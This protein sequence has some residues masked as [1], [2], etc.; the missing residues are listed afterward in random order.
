MSNP[1]FELLN[2]IYDSITKNKLPFG[3]ACSTLLVVGTILFFNPFQILESDNWKDWKSHE[4]YLFGAFLISII[5]VICFLFIFLKNYIY[6]KKS[7]SK[8]PSDS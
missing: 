2:K 8:K 5:I 1:L 4:I 7:K 6:K 3:L